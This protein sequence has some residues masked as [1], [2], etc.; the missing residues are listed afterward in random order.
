MFKILCVRSR[1]KQ[2]FHI[3]K[4]SDLTNI[5][6]PTQLR[7][8]AHVGRA[9]LIVPSALYGQRPSR[10]RGLGVVTVDLDE[11]LA[12]VQD[13]DVCTGCETPFF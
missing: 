13:E 4:K 11:E 6:I 3:W 10:D 1:S 12:L 9:P 8:A 2:L 7:N 5:P